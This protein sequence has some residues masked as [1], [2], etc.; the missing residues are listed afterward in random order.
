MRRA[1]G[2]V[3]RFYQLIPLYEEERAM[4]E[5]LGTKAL[6][7]AFQKSGVSD[8]IRADRVNVAT[9]MGA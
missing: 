2:R 5:R 8:V 9:A 1:D 6:I 4:K 3:V 7:E